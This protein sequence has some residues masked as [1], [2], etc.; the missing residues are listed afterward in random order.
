MTT[1]FSWLLTVVV[2]VAFYF[3]LFAPSPF[4]RGLFRPQG[5]QDHYWIPAVTG[6]AAVA[7][8]LQSRFDLNLTIVAIGVA[9][10]VV[11][12]RGGYLLRLRRWGDWIGGASPAEPEEAPRL[13]IAH[14]LGLTFCVA[15]VFAVARWCDWD[16]AAMV[17]AGSA[18][19]G[20]I[21]LLG[22]WVA[23]L[24]SSV[25][26]ATALASLGLLVARRSRGLAFPTHPGEYLWVL[27]GVPLAIALGTAALGSEMAS[28]LGIHL[29]AAGGILALKVWACLQM[30]R[31]HW[32]AYL[33]VWIGCQILTQTLG[34]LLLML[35]PGQLTMTFAIGTAVVN[36]LVALGLI[37]PLLVDRRAG[38][39]RPWSHWVGVLLWLLSAAMGLVGMVVAWLR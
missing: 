2:A 5:P 31:R 17:G 35:W 26:M 15:L 7:W 37:W 3:L 21:A 19:T 8:F 6:V 14:L 27:V 22:R 28:A 20:G 4:R 16:L 24:L 1:P 34:W 13:S 9:S 30:Q 25:G 11:V 23:V 39:R 36:Q 12:A 38:I 18:D 10:A 29:L 32:R 33:G